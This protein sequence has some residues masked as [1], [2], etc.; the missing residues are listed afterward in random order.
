MKNEEHP[1][2][3][4][5]PHSAFRIPHSKIISLLTDFGLDDP[6]VGIMKGVILSINPDIQL[7]DLTHT[8]PFGKIEA[9]AFHLKTAHRW[10]PG[11]TIHLV[12]VD[13]GVGGSR[14]ALAVKA[15]EQYF[16]AP[17]NGIL[18]E[19]FRTY[20]DFTAYAIENED[21]T[22]R[23][24]SS[25]FHGR[26]VFAPA[27]AHLSTGVSIE[28]LGRRVDDPVILEAVA[29]TFSQ[30]YISIRVLHIDRFGNVI[31]NLPLADAIRLKEGKFRFQAGESV[32]KR[33]YHTYEMIPKGEPGLIP[34]SSGYI[35]IAFK[36][37]S[38]ADKLNIKVGDELMIK[39]VEG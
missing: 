26:D 10:F 6:F 37:D 16:I 29:P 19:I 36:D 35:E 21:Y 18:T 3:S 39:I 17:D 1:S 23:E 34:G 32:I 20:P 28:S 8:I 13:P 2:P 31:T 11:G 15:G 30:G 38:A 27:A 25:T 7:V 4:N 22:L 9:A 14:R 5:I 12:V 24:K 33:I